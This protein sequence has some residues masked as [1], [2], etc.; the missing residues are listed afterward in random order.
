MATLVTCALPYAN[1]DLH[2]GHLR[3]YIPGDCLARALRK[4][5][6]DVVFVCGSDM[7]GTPIVV[8]AE[9]GG[10]EPEELA[11]RYHEYFK[12]TFPKIGV[13]FDNYGH[14][15]QE[16]N[17][18]RTTEI[19][20]TLE[21]RGFI[22]EQ[23]MVV[24][25]DPKEERTLPDRYVEGR[26]PYCG[27]EEARGDEC[28]E[29]GRH[30]E[31]GELENPISKIS[32]SPAEYIEQ[33][34][35]FFELSAFKDYLEEFIENLEGTEN[36]KNQP[37]QWIED[38]EDWCITRDLDW[39]VPYPGEDD[40]TLYVWVDAPIEYISSTEEWAKKQ[41]GDWKKFWKRGQGDIVHVI[42]GDIIQH[43]CVFWPALLKGA[44]YSEPK[45]VLASGLVK[46]DD[47]AFSTSRGRAVWLDQ[48][49]L[50][51]GFSPDLIRYYI[52]SYTGFERDLNFSWDLFQEKVN[53]ELVDD[54]GNFVYRS[55]LLAY[56]EYNG[57]PKGEIQTEVLQNIQ[58]SIDEFQESVEKYDIKGISESFMRLARFGNK[59]IQKN[60]PW[61]KKQGSEEIIY[62]CLQISK[63]LAILTEPVMP[64]V[65]ED[66]WK[67][68]SLDQDK[69][70]TT[71]L[72][73]CI[74]PIDTKINQPSHLFDQIEDSKIQKLNER[75]QERIQTVEGSED[76]K[77][78]KEE[79]DVKNKQDMDAKIEPIQDDEVPFE[80]FKELDI[81]VGKIEKAQPID[82][83]DDLMVLEIDIGV[84]KRQA[85]AG[86]KQIYDSEDIVGEKVIAVANMEPT[87]LFG[88]KSEAMLLAAGE[89][90]DLLTTKKD[91]NL[92]TKVK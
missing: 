12:E 8:N 69:L 62:N 14:T 87:E 2:L 63:A 50:D 83:S 47:K 79:K 31:P 55:L 7:H 78:A 5:G 41:N 45:A 67:Q 52:A 22:Y 53:S 37:R 32:E 27:V 80:D 64:F 33:K 57:E 56:D 44:G 39:G 20:E 61:S 68:L 54:L 26:C 48:D 28:D 11:L 84:E 60:E 18:K 40:L 76:K 17:I 38:L 30:L 23:D 21:E 25:Y 46:V 34:H 74:E 10:V 70:Q 43:H 35:K 19:V 71:S 82:E 3:T 49:Y 65:A 58:K 59:Y 16:S 86:I 89:K 75:L 36:A 77:E 4:T 1:G 85:V 29:C 66:L 73:D 9:E 90:A 51:E 13:E 91:S 92:G 15:D 81:R 72:N 88:Y 24:A 42:G 6:E